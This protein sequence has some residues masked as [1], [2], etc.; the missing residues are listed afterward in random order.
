[1]RMLPD[2]PI[3]PLQLPALEEDVGVIKDEEG[4]KV[5]GLN[6]EQARS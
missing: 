1:M 4:G 3:M 5:K 2:Y 6:P